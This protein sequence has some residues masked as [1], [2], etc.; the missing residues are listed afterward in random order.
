MAASPEVIESSR[1]LQDR[2]N[3]G[4][5][6]ERAE[7]GEFVCCLKDVGA[8][9]VEG[10]LTS[11]RSYLVGYIHSETRVHIFTVHFFMDREGNVGASG[12]YDPKCMSSR[13]GV[14][15]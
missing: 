14:W 2:F 3:R 15:S 6:I 11:K 8:E 10:N 13:L 7:R 1:E 9:R 5:Y 12:Q 4:K